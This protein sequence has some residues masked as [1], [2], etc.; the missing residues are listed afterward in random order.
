MRDLSTDW[1]E[2]TKIDFKDNSS[3]I[4]YRLTAIFEDMK[5]ELAYMQA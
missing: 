5:H 3:S 2:N 1:K 4:W